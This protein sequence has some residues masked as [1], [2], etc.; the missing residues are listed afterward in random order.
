[1]MTPPE[2]ATL[3]VNRA[4]R[5]VARRFDGDRC[6]RYLRKRGLDVQLEYPASARE[7][8]AAAATA[9][10]RGDDLVF[11]AGGDGSVRDVATA[12]A[13]TATALAALPMGTVNVWAR[14]TGIPRGLRAAIDTHLAGQRVRAD[15]GCAGAHRF[16]LMAGIGWDALIAR[17]VRPRFKQSFGDLA[18]VLQAAQMLPCLRPVRTRWRADGSEREDQLAQMVLSNTRLYGGM[19]HLA[20]EASA[21]DGLLDGLALTPHTVIDFTRLAAR[22]ALGRLTGDRCAE[23]FRVRAV[24]VLTP[25]LPVQ[26]DGDYTGETPMRFSVQQQALLV[27]I[28]AGPL[29]AIL[30]GAHRDGAAIPT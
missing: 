1:M 14:E 20:P 11:V 29:P 10:G 3:I 23:R 9:A 30:R 2:R 4:A 24:E 18:Y 28:P 5:G 25:G 7:A 17:S 16:L 19:V 6:L 26:L 12:L 21:G 22:L 15:L 27:S 13:G 8:T